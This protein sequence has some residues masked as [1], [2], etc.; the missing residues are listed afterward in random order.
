MAEWNV[1]TLVANVTCMHACLSAIRP[2]MSEPQP[3]NTEGCHT[4]HTH[5]IQG[6]RD[7]DE[8]LTIMKSICA[9][10]EP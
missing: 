7:M 6:N 9:L 3:S 10:L 2:F 5:E 4:F 1:G 8:I